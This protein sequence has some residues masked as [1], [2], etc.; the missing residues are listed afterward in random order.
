MR[1]AEKVVIIHTNDLHS[2]FETMPRI[3]T[4][5]RSIRDRRRD[6]FCILADI[7]DHA[8]RMRLETEGTEGMANRAVLDYCGYDV[9]VPG[10]NEGLT[11]SKRQL[12]ALYGEDAGFEAVCCNM[13]EYGTLEPLP[14]LKPYRIMTNGRVNVGLIGVT[15][16]F[17][18][19]YH[20]LGWHLLPPLEAVAKWTA[21]LR[22]KVDLLIVCSHLGLHRDKEMAESIPGIDCI[23]GGHTHHV[24]EEPLMIGDTMICAAGKYGEYVGA[25]EF[26]LDPDR[27]TILSR[28]AVCHD[29]SVFRPDPSLEQLILRYRMQA[30]DKLGESVVDLPV[31][32]DNAWNTESPLGNLLARGLKEWTG[33]EAAIVNAGQILGPLDCGSITR[34]MILEICPSPIN[35]CR[36]KLQGSAIKQ[37][38]EESLLDEFIAMPIKG[39]GFR[40]KAL[41]TLCLD[42]I[43]VEYDPH[44]P[45]FR[46]ITVIRVNGEDL[47]ED[48]WYDVAT[49]DMFTF[50]I[51]YLS[52]KQG[53]DIVYY[54]P[55]FIRDV[56]VSQLRKPDNVQ[57]S[58]RPRWKPAR[59]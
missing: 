13:V 32:L 15:A 38:L 58:F 36:M 22:A 1:S 7:G 46:K 47:D 28:S 49:I 16:D 44:A 37:A 40:G 21:F 39:F 19:F 17:N 34:E 52:L 6:A 9:A 8:D 55:E 51:G 26:V 33:A 43:Q 11:L 20:E 31:R 42:G 53:K 12:A 5:I 57:D 18:D 14:W 2:H 27:K 50:G 25:A 10:N 30:K 41:G 45:A 4:A 59:E 3:S 56:L 24:L 35:P 23:L 54:L 48:R 29:P